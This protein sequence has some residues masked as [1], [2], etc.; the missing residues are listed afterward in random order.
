MDS[1]K[2][3]DPEVEEEAVE[4]EDSAVEEEAVESWRLVSWKRDV[5]LRR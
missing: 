4:K 3:M 2:K 5:V 1:T